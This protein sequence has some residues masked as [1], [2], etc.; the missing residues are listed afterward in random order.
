MKSWILHSLNAIRY[1]ELL[2][3]HLHPFMLFFY[4]HGNGSCMSNESRLATG[5]LEEHFSEF[6]VI[7]W[8]PRSPDLNPLVH[9]WYVLE[10]GGKGHHT[11]P[12]KLSELGEA[13]A[14]IFQSI[15]VKCFQKIVDSMPRRVAAIINA[16]R[17]PTRY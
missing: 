4:P 9:L 16:S 7:N 5:W 15:P 1:V 12:R 8:P 2:G 6:S 17:G 10:Q 3:D 14:N 11:A 13:L